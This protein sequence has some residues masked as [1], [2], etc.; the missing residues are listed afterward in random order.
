[1]NESDIWE[2]SVWYTWTV[3]DLNGDGSPVAYSI[4]TSDGS[5]G[6]D[7]GLNPNNIIGGD[8]DTQVAI[9]RCTLWS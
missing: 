9:N 6:D 4:W 3:P 8:A 2:N 5:F 7:C 1:M